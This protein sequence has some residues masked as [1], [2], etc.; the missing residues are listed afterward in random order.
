[1]KL[2]FSSIVSLSLLIQQTGVSEIVVSPAH[3]SLNSDPNDIEKNDMKQIVMRTI[4]S[5]KEVNMN[6]DRRYPIMLEWISFFTKK[7]YY[8]LMIPIIA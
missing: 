1:M 2:L 7:L 8:K 4:Q 3:S 5:V 6:I